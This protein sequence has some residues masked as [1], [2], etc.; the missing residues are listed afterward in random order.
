MSV[1]FYHYHSGRISK[2]YKQIITKPVC[3]PSKLS[4]GPSTPSPNFC[5]V[6]VSHL[7]MIHLSQQQSTCE[8]ISQ[9]HFRVSLYVPIINNDENEFLWQRAFATTTFAIF[10]ISWLQPSFCPLLSLRL[11]VWLI[12]KFSALGDGIIAS[13][14]NSSC[15]RPHVQYLIKSL[16]LTVMV[17]LARRH[18]QSPEVKFRLPFLGFK[19]CVAFSWPS[20]DRFGENVWG[21]MTIA[22][23]RAEEVLH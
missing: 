16:Y 19:S 5:H 11:K 17:G 14:N 21:P 22:F 3:G 15:D 23:S 9:I 4:S 1:L 6:S 10:G 2:I 20:V 18:N 8:L 12:E 13:G 7:P